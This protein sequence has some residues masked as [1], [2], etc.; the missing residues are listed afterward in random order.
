MDRYTPL[1]SDAA[2]I[3]AVTPSSTPLAIRMD[4][5]PFR[6]SSSAPTIAIAPT[7][8]SRDAVTKPFTKFASSP[9]P[10]NRV[11]HHAPKSLSRVS[12]SSASP[13]TAPSTRLSTSSMVCWVERVPSSMVSRPLAAP[14][15]PMKNVHR[16]S[17]CRMVVSKRR[18]SP[19]LSRTPSVVPA[20]IMQQFTMVPSPIISC[21]APLLL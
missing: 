15:M 14:P 12:I 16:P 4:G 21:I 3:T 8:N 7:Q 6:P 2:K 13:T 18:D 9:L 17:A 19:P 10:E 11:W 1:P 20:A 5:S